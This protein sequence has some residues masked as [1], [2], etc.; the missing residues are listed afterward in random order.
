MLYWI[1]IFSVWIFSKIVFR[2][3]ANG[4]NNIPATQGFILASNH[5]SYLDP[6]IVASVCPRR[7]NFMARYELFAVPIL[8][9]FIRRVGAFPLRRNSADITSIK[10]AFRRLSRQEGLLLFPEGSRLVQGSY[11]LGVGFLAVKSQ[12]PVVPVFINGAQKALGCSARFIRPV[13]IKVYFGRP[14]Y[15]KKSNLKSYY[16]DFAGRIMQEINRLGEGKR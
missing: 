8:G 11:R 15:P 16:E 9:Y 2:L 3:E 4:L 1:T 10:E 7:L 13:K 14:L 12:V 6:C 5:A